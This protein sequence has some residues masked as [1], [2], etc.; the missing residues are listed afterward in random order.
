MELEELAVRLFAVGRDRVA[1][2]WKDANSWKGSAAATADG[3][4]E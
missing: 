4:A 1:S 2:V 3:I